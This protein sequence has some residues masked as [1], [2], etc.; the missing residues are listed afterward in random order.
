MNPEKVV[1]KDVSQLMKAVVKLVKQ[2][3]ADQSESVTIAHMVDVFRGSKSK[4]VKPHLSL[5]CS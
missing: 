4:K 1:K 5:L 3:T 2:I